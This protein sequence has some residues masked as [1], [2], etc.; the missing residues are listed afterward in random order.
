MDNL[1]WKNRIVLII[2]EEDSFIKKQLEEIGDFE[3]EFQERKL[4]IIEVEKERIRILS[5]SNPSWIAEKEIFEN[6]FHHDEQSKVLLVGLDGGVKF[7]QNRVV[8]RKEIFD[9]IDTM[10]MRKLELKRKHS[11]F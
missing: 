6:Y 7:R 3:D 10:P 11:N 8:S 9:L 4:M 5:Q 2:A 1:L